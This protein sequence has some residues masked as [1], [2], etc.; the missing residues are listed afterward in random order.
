ITGDST[1]L[2]PYVQATA[3]I[4]V[5]LQ[6]LRKL[7]ADNATQRQRLDNLEPLGNSSIRA[8]Q[9]EIDM[10]KTGT[11]APE[12]LLPL[13]NSLRK[14]TDDTR[15]TISDMEAEA[16]VLLRER[17]EEAQR[18]NHQTNLLILFTGLTAFVL[19]GAAGVALYVDITAR[20]QT[21][22]SRIKAHE[23]LQRTNEE[24]EK[25]V[26][27]RRQAELRL[28]DSE[29]SLRQLSMRLIQTQ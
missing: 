14:A 11:V 28:R 18:S 13:E 26:A 29:Q 17:N 22:A 15:L 23:E 8:L 19:L 4:R 10:R 9:N 12:K 7:T 5:Q 3:D 2:T 21:E 6:S 25:E 20:G 16:S 24:L 27:E 1:Y